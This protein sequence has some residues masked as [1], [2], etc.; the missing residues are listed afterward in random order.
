MRISGLCVLTGC[1]DGLFLVS[2]GHRAP[3]EA[4]T[5][6]VP[7][8]V[9]LRKPVFFGCNM[10]IEFRPVTAS[11]SKLSPILH[12]RDSYHGPIARWDCSTRHFGRQDT[13]RYLL[14]S[15]IISACFL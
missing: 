8:A 11:P 15:T 4:V 14:R 10:G 1:A 7:K 9:S 13:A 6:P 3:S 5:Q 12:D 2:S